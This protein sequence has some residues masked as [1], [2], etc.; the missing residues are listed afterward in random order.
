MHPLSGITVIELAGL[1]PAPFAGMI[2]ADFGADV[3]RVDR[4]ATSTTD[5]LARG[6]RSISIDLKN[7]HGREVVKKIMEKVDVV[8]DPFRPGVLEKMGLGPDTILKINPKCIFARLTGFGQTGDFAGGGMLCAMGILIALIERQKSG[9]GQVIDSAMIDGSTY[10]SAFIIKMRQLGLWN[11]E[12]GQNLLDSGAP[13]YETY[14]TK[15][16]KFLAVGAIEPQFYKRFIKGLGIDTS[17]LPQQMDMEEFGNMKLKF[18]E[19]FLQKTRD[20][21]MKIYDRTDACVTPI[22]E[23]DEVMDL[24]HNK[25]R[26]FMVKNS[27]GDDFDPR[28]APRLL[29][30]PGRH[31]NGVEQADPLIGEH[32]VQVL[33]QFGF[34]EKVITDLQQNKIIFTQKQS[35]L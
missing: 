15:D 8:I 18:K 34:E 33:R 25:D 30:T 9:K 31:V 23:W 14:K 21:W 24:K 12:R 28:P 4:I 19:I 16:G 29:R 7:A 11:A 6:K 2:L 17:T 35:K 13:F 1:A 32:S 27:S 5:V 26:N 22:L 10:L 20:E 3:I